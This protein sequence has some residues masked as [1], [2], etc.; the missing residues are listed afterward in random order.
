MFLFK[1]GRKLALMAVCLFA[2]QACGAETAAQGTPEKAELTNYGSWQPVWLD[3]LQRLNRGG[4]VKFRIVQIGDSHTA[5]DYFTNE[6]RTRLQQQWGD[7]GIGWVYPNNV[8]GQRN[9][10]VLHSSS[11]WQVLSSRN[12]RAEFPLGGILNRSSGGG[13]TTVNP[14]KPI[15]E[16][17]QVTI[18]ARPVF[19]D[20]AL[21]VQ[22]AQ[23]RQVASLPNLGSNAWQ[24]FSF[25]AQLPLSYRSQP[26]DIWEI[27]HINIEN[28]RPGVIVS[29]MGINGSQLSQWGSWRAD[30][31]QDLSATQADLVILAYGTN[32]AF[33]SHLDVAQTKRI[34]AET[35]G[36]IR[37]AL[38][39]AGI[40]IIGAPESLKSKHGQCGQRPPY[41]DAVQQM[42]RDVAQQEQTLY[43]S[44]QAAMGGPCSMKG[45]VARGLGARDG[46][47]FSAQGYQTAA[48]QLADDIIKLANK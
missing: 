27:G 46:V 23:G 15:G 4:N 6:L 39:G 40:L 45:W 13:H 3:K 19:A 31:M 34:W 42:Q 35:V 12:A 43:W 18:I 28:D 21:S 14:R 5:G 30:W 33:N 16:A 1:E 38:P 9:A 8:A 37:E 36:R 47:H 44:W 32:E 41:L 2:C 22:D 20:N 17:Q 7:G 26:G 48:S 29:A 24:Y 10:Q 11:G 25:T